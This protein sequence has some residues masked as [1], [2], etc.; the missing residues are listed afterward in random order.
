MIVEV[1][2]ARLADAARIHSVS[3]CES[4]RSF[5]SPDFIA[6]HTPE[7]QEARLL[8]EMAQGKR[9]YMMLDAGRSVGIVSVKE[10][11]I[12]NLYVLPDAQR[13]G[14]GTALLLHAAGLCPGDPVLWVLENNSGARALYLRRGFRE[15]GK[16]SRLTDT[17][18]ELEMSRPR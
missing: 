11:L 13:R 1:N 6:L 10:N 15:T 16:R 4:H 14:F 12:E 8:E 3:W 2:R 9:F 17:L 18:S 5:C 7:R